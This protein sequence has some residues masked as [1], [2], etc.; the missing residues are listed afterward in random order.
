MILFAAF[1]ILDDGTCWLL[2]TCKENYSSWISSLYLEMVHVQNYI[3][4]IQSN[5]CSNGSEEEG[6]SIALSNSS[7]SVLTGLMQG[8]HPLIVSFLYF[9][10]GRACSPESVCRTRTLMV[11]TLCLWQ[12]SVYSWSWFPYIAWR[13]SRGFSWKEFLSSK[14]ISVSLSLSFSLSTGSP[15]SLS[16][17]KLHAPPPS[18]RYHSKL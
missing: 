18:S 8:I 1:P 13:I 15:A 14:W 6:N 3:I 16:S 7:L 10:G 2:P 12:P 5:I 17:L 11:W 4:R 9:W